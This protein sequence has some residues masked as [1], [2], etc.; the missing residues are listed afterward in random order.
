MGDVIS[1]LSGIF[2]LAFIIANLI[3]KYE[4][5]RKRKAARK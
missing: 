3:G 4:E 5:A 2:L 1:V